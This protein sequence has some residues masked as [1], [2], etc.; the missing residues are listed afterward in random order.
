M[1]ILLTWG[2]IAPLD[3]YSTTELGYFLGE[4]LVSFEPFGS[5]CDHDGVCVALIAV[6]LTWLHMLI[7]LQNHYGTMEGG[8]WVLLIPE[9]SN[10]QCSGKSSGRIIHTLCCWWLPLYFQT[11]LSVSSRRC[12]RYAGNEVLLYTLTSDGEILA[13]FPLYKHVC[14]NFFQFHADCCSIY[15][16]SSTHWLTSLLKSLCNLNNYT[17]S[18][19]YNR[20]LN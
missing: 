18:A 19:H 9:L 12:F 16:C 1:I 11:L 13:S 4:T 10:T 20:I 8:H 5:N 3:P 15:T 17:S 14:L 6:H 2:G 7:A